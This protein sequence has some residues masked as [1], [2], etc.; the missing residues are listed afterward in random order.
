MLK[1]IKDDKE[2]DPSASDT[3]VQDTQIHPFLSSCVLQV[4][5][6]RSEQLLQLQSECLPLIKVFILTFIMTFPRTIFVNHC[7]LSE[8]VDANATCLLTQSFSRYMLKH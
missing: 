8:F 5:Q 1:V 4:D 2:R 6:R 3:D 7:L